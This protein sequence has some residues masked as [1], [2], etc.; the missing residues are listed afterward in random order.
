MLC[1][2][3]SDNPKKDKLKITLTTNI[4]K[5]TPII[6]EELTKLFFIFKLTCFDLT[7]YTPNKNKAKCAI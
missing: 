3:L 2:P 7:I 5:A 4:N 1:L 6:I